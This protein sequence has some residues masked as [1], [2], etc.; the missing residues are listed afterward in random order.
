MLRR[1]S[2]TIYAN[3][4]ELTKYILKDAPLVVFYAT[5]LIL[6]GGLLSLTTS[7]DIKLDKIKDHKTALE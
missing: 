5:F 7:V 1:S 6:A 3:I 2:I 4:P